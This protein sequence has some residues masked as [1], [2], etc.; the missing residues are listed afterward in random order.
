KGSTQ[1]VERQLESPVTDLPVVGVGTRSFREP[2]LTP[3]AEILGEEPVA[4]VPDRTLRL[5]QVV[6][7]L[8]IRLL[9]EAYVSPGEQ[10]WHNFGVVRRTKEDSPTRQLLRPLTV[11]V[12]HAQ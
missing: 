4:L 9:V 6:L 2:S 7:R 12:V 11:L 10:P 1:F 3:V 8:V 5:E